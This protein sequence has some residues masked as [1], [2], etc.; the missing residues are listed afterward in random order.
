MKT[1]IPKKYSIGKYS[2]SEAGL[3]NINCFKR[4]PE[5]ITIPEGEGQG[6]YMVCDGLATSKCKEIA[7]NI[8]VEYKS[9]W[10]TDRIAKAILEKV[11]GNSYSNPTR[12]AR[13]TVYNLAIFDDYAILH[14]YDNDGFGYN[15]S[16]K[17]ACYIYKLKK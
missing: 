11:L 5:S 3:S 4:R 16:I 12:G 8:G 6:T 2:Y 10:F 15:D 7:N 13:Q 14:E 9:S 1:I 17:K